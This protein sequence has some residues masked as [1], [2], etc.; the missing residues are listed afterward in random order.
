ML[1]TEYWRGWLQPL[2][3]VDVVLIVGSTM[4]ASVSEN[5]ACQF[6]GL[7][8]ADHWAAESLLVQHWNQAAVIEVSM[9]EQDEVERFWFEPRNSFIP[10][11]RGRFA[12]LH[13]V[14][15]K[16]VNVESFVA[17]LVARAGDLSEWSV[18]SDLHRSLLG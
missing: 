14:V 16:A 17:Q 8:G 7:S 6:R 1:T 13:A 2:D 10:A 9:R 5:D 3:R 18:K 12:L 11:V 15:D 4:F